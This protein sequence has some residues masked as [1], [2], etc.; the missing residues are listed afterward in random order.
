MGDPL[1]RINMKQIMGLHPQR[2]Q[3]LEQTTQR[4]RIII[5]PLQQHALI[6]HRDPVRNQTAQRR[7]RLP[8]QLIRMVEMRHEPQSVNDGK[9]FR[10]FFCN[11]GRFHRGRPGAD[12]DGLHPAGSADPGRHVDH[13]VVIENQRISSAQQHIADLRILIQPFADL[14]KILIGKGKPCGAVRPEPF[15]E[16]EAAAHK[17]F[18]RR[19]QNRAV[20]VAADQIRHRTL[21]QLRQSIRH[22][23]GILQLPEIRQIEPRH[24]RGR[25]R[26]RFAIGVQFDGIALQHLRHLSVRLRHSHTNPLP[27]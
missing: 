13:A 21:F 14:C 20:P 2:R 26:Q 24:R 4:L 16:T 18:R 7:F 19:Q 22:K 10:Q 1:H 3:T 27:S 15:P 11:P 23:A 12:P 9:A 25:L 6:Q 17:A 5:D 8:C